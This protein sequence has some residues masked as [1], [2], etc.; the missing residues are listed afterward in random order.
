MKFYRQ[1][2]QNN[3]WNIIHKTYLIIIAILQK[4]QKLLAQIH[5]YFNLI[6]LEYLPSF[7]QKQKGLM[8]RKSINK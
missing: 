3:V 8:W 5:T 7:K 6:I 4:T 1:K 2:D